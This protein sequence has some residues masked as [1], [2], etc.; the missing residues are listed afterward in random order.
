MKKLLQDLRD[1]MIA[2]L[3]ELLAVV[4][5]VLVIALPP[6]IGLYCGYQFERHSFICMHADGTTTEIPPP[7]HYRRLDGDRVVFYFSGGKR[8]LYEC[9]DIS[10]GE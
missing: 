1:W 3:A 7:A 4:V 2:R 8:R 10:R 5:V 6:I 9:I